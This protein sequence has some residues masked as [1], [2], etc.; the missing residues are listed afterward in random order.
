M[1]KRYWSLIDSP[2]QKFSAWV[3]DEGRLLRFYLRAAGAAKV[4]P[5]AEN[6]SR[7]LAEVQRQV[8][9][10]ANGKRRDFDFELAAEGPEFRIAR[11]AVVALMVVTMVV[12]F[13]QCV[14]SILLQASI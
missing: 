13:W 11:L 12:F 6:N 8:T 5:E 1:S 4:D 7:K 14:Y 9:Q 3:D 2:F 10:Y